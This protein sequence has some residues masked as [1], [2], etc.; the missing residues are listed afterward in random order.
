MTSIFEE[1]PMERVRRY[2]ALAERARDR[3]ERIP[4]Q[5]LRLSYLRMAQSWE[6]LAFETEREWHPPWAREARRPEL[7]AAG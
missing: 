4:A 6:E 7:L 3:A 2:L 1:S 5:D